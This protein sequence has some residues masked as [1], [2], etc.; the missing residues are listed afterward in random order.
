MIFFGWLVLL[1]LSVNYAI[2][3]SNKNYVMWRTEK[4]RSVESDSE[5]GHEL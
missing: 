3:S 4:N 5:E 1:A 2:I